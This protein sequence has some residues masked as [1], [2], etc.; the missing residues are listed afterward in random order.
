M[1]PDQDL[2]MLMKKYPQ[3][4]VESNFSFKNSTTFFSQRMTKL[5]YTDNHKQ[6]IVY[7]F[8]GNLSSEELGYFMDEFSKMFLQK[9]NISQVILGAKNIPTA[10]KNMLD[11]FNVSWYEIDLTLAKKVIEQQEST[12]INLK[13][14]IERSKY[15]DALLVF[16]E[17]FLGAD[18]NTSWDD[19]SLLVSDQQV[20]KVE[21]ESPNCKERV[22]QIYYRHQLRYEGLIQITYQ[23][24]HELMQWPDL[25]TVCMTEVNSLNEDTLRNDVFKL[26]IDFQTCVDWNTGYL[27][28]E[29]LCDDDMLTERDAER[30]QYILQKWNLHHNYSFHLAE[31]E[32]ADL[33]Y[34]IKKL[35]S[36]TLL[37]STANSKQ[38]IS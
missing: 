25:L 6:K 33:E 10:Y 27:F 8:H 23:K 1:R 34:F 16:T 17:G 5:E 20:S 15:H 35:I 14:R 18:L 2:V 32:Q 3:L 30:I 13:N 37:K 29:I 9:T 19:F 12:E 22:F 36:I 31:Y 38:P 7:F 21:G 4:V 26:S 28:T 11:H 24:R